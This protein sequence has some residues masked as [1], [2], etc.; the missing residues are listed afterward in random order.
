ML[1]ILIF[2]IICITIFYIIDESNELEFKNH[3]ENKYEKICII[4]EKK[5][6]NK[7]LL[8]HYN[9]NKYIKKIIY[10]NFEDVLVNNYYSAIN[11]IKILRKLNEL[12]DYKI[13]PDKISFVIKYYESLPYALNHVNIL[14]IAKEIKKLHDKNI[15]HNDIHEDNIIYD[16]DKF[17]IID[18]GSSSYKRS[19]I[20]F[21]FCSKER[22]K[23][24]API[25]SYFLIHSK[26]GD[27][28]SFGKMISKSIFIKNTMSLFF[29]KR[30]DI[31]RVI[32][33]LE[34][35]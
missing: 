18:Y 33:Y 31:E 20:D 32:K 5:F 30:M 28:Y 10:N 3:F 23:D 14:S 15:I 35:S 7:V 34:I 25:E 26:K 1:I 16:G 29:W 27:I 4:S 17:H 19:F 2:I 9:N 11:E 8:V 6:K 12:I 22:L 13:N 24:Y 21:F